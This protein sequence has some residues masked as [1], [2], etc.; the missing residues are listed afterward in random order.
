MKWVAHE[1]DS[2]LWWCAGIKRLEAKG[3]RDRVS[4]STFVLMATT[5]I[6][7]AA[8][9][10]VPFFG[11]EFLPPFNEGSLTINSSCRSAP[12]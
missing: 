7:L 10:T 1:A 9:A 4:H 11:R 12:R 2:W 8:V 5:A 3:A 6:F